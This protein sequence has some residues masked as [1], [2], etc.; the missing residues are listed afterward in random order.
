MKLRKRA[1]VL[2]VLIV[3]AVGLMIY[4]FNR[5]AIVFVDQ[6]DI[7][8]NSSVDAASFIEKVRGHEK[9]EVKIDTSMRNMNWKWKLLI[10]KH[11]LSISR[12]M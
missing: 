8:I 5:P 2:L 12:K 10:P 9:R 11:R 4:L 3:A 6:T 1:I 7:E